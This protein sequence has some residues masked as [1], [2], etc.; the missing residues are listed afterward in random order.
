MSRDY[1]DRREQLREVCRQRK[2][3]YFGTSPEEAVRQRFVFDL[4]SQIVYC[5]TEKVGSTLWR[6][7][8]QVRRKI[9][10]KYLIHET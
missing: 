8:F 10:K 6:R 1:R 9:C 2:V 4:N 7:L 5:A 3:T